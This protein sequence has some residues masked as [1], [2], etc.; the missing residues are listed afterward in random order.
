M[1]RVSR[2]DASSG[3]NIPVSFHS[4]SALQSP[5]LQAWGFEFYPGTAK[6][7]TLF[8][9]PGFDVSGQI[10]GVQMRIQEDTYCAPQNW[11]MV[12]PTSRKLMMLS[13]G[14]SGES[15]SILEERAM[16]TE[17]FTKKSELND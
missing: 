12:R 11:L 13:N 5:V 15:K 2:S 3:Y 17:S 4:S 14:R 10:S 9:N 1:R 16:D 6:E 8:Q 7:Y